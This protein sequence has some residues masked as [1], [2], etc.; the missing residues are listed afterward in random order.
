MT[1]LAHHPVPDVDDAVERSCRKRS[2]LR[3]PVPIDTGRLLSD[4]ASIPDDLWGVSYWDNHCSIDVLLLRG[5]T[6]GNKNDFASS[7][8]SNTP[9]LE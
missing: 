5:G 1:D 6:E 3:L 9:V 4:Y 2:F 8:V 7:G